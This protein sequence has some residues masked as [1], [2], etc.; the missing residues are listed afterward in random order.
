MEQRR[1]PHL[2][3]VAAGYTAM[4]RTQGDDRIMADAVSDEARRRFLKLAAAGIAAAPLGGLPAMRQARAQERVSEDDKLARQVG[5][6]QDANQVDA[7]KWPLYEKGHVCAKCQF[8]HGRQG[9]EWGSCDVFG[10]KLVH[11]RGW[12]S[13][14]TAR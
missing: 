3:I 11:S 7:S 1:Q 14:W 10:G 4:G 8:F 13:E 9:D 6:K 5:Y 2:G 12:C